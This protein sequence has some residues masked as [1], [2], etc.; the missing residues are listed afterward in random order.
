MRIGWVYPHRERCGIAQYA[1][2]YADVLRPHTELADIDPQWWTD[3]RAVVRDT[4][5]GCDI[6]H[7]QYDTAA[8]MRG[9][10][11]FFAEMMRSVKVPVVVSLHEVYDEDPAVFPRSRISGR[12]PAR[13]FKRIVWDLRHPVQYAFTRHC[14]QSFFARAVL[15]HQRYHT[16]I[17]VRKNCARHIVRVEPFPVKCRR[18]MQESSF[19]DLPAIR[20]GAFGFVNPLFDY[21]LLFAAL[22]QLRRPWTFTWLGGV[23]NVS[24]QPLHDALTRRL[25]AENWSDRF[26][27]TGW[28]PE[29]E[30]P[31]RFADIDIVCALFT[32]RSSSASIAEV[33]GA[34]KP[35]VAASIPLTREI[36][37]VNK[38][39]GAP[40]PLLLTERDG[41]GVAAAIERLCADG[42][43]RADLY[44]GACAYRDAT[45]FEVMAG[46]LLA[47]Y[48]ELLAA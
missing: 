30:L 6:V 28:V 42:G 7:V 11:D 34:G 24:Q 18:A 32:G 41:A 22:K 45:S 17:V 16:D 8:F 48:R 9:R 3:R 20:L 27:V 15:V 5:V 29:E 2:D 37:S 10:R 19:P 43:L 33:L 36:A 1:R 46:R 25:A 39:A 12:F 23:G 44:R 47:M 38:A 35:V 31:L 13:Q 14:A 21:E 40:A 26:H 4:I